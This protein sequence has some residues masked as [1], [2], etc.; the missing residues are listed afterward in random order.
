MLSASLKKQ[1]QTA[2]ANPMHRAKTQR[3][4]ENQC[5]ELYRTAC[6]KPKDLLFWGVLGLIPLSGKS[7]W[8]PS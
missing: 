7:S 5:Q 6:G 1:N 3:R 2:K 8:F 4:K